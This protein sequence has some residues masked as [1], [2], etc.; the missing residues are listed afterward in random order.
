[1]NSNRS[2]LV[3]LGVR[4][5]GDRQPVVALACGLRER[6]H[7]VTVLCDS[8]TEQLIKPTGLPTITIPP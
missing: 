7:R 3:L 2:V 8:A 6:G 4:G 1:M 5:G